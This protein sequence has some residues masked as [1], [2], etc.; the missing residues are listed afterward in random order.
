MV[1]VLIVKP[2]GITEFMARIEEVLYAG[3]ATSHLSR[4]QRIRRL[5]VISLVNKPPG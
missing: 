4:R 1:S 3:P 5:A 2:E